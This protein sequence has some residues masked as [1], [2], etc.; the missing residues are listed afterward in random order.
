MANYISHCQI[1]NRIFLKKEAALRH[2]IR[3][4]ME[5]QKIE[6]AAEHLRAA[7]LQVFKARGIKTP[8]DI[9]ILQHDLVLKWLSISTEDLIEEYRRKET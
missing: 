5:A 1:K 7:K 9:S 4:N 2:A 8:S 3:S 6:A